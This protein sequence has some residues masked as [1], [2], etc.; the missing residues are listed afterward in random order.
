MATWSVHL[1]GLKTRQYYEVQRYF[2]VTL[3]LPY[4][5]R[6]RPES[7]RV[8]ELE[9]IGRNLGK[10]PEFYRYIKILAVETL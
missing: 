4:L 1:T 5:R 2:K 7:W 6:S 9:Q 10:L 8:D 3:I